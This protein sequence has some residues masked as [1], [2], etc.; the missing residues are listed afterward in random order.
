MNHIFVRAYIG[1]GY[2]DNSG[3]GYGDSRF[4]DGLGNGDGYGEGYGNNS[5]DGNGHGYFVCSNGT[6]RVDL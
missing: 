2:D 1:N 6:R 3:N 5:G 4:G